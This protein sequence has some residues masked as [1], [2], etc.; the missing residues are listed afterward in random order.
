MM[1]TCEVSAPVT[2]TAIGTQR[3]RTRWM[4]LRVAIKANHQNFI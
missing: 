3:F 2:K 1:K 4:K